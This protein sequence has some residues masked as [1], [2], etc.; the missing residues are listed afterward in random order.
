MESAWAI[1]AFVTASGWA[2]IARMRPVLSDV[3]RA[4][5]EVVARKAYA[6]ARAVTAAGSVI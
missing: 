5:D 4:R 6:I 2:P 1:S 3:V